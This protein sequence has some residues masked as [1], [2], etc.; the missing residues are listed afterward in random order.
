MADSIEGIPLIRWRPSTTIP[1]MACG[2]SGGHITKHLDLTQLYGEREFTRR[3]RLVDI[4]GDGREELISR[5]MNEN[6]IR[7]MD[8]RT[9]QT[10]WVSPLIL[11]SKDHPPISDLAVGDI[12]NDGQPEAVIATYDG[13]ILCIDATNG[14]I[15]W[16]RK[17]DYHLDYPGL[18]LTNITE[19]EGLE[20]AFTVSN[21]FEWNRNH[22]RP[23]TN[24]LLNPSV[25]VL[26][27]DGSHAW[28]SKNYDAHNSR[29]HWTWEFD[30]D[31]DGY[32][33]IV[34]SGVNKII[35]FDNDGTRLFSVPFQNSGHADRVV[36]G[37]WSTAHPG[38]EII[39]TDGIRG[40][41]VASNSGEVLDYLDI[42]TKLGG[43]LQDITLIPA[44]KEKGPHLLAQ[45]IRTQ[46]AKTTLYDKE[47]KPVWA[48]QLGY[49]AA[50]QYT[51]VLD[52]DR[53]GEYEIATGSVAAGMD[54]QCS[55]QIMELDG[56]PL[57]WHRWNG[58]QICWIME[59]KE[60][61]PSE[62]SSLLLGTGS[63]GGKSGR[64]SLPTGG[65][66]NLFVVEAP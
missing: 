3:T 25:L 22:S 18:R 29:G 14:N 31:G 60:L 32:D 56:S 57:Y 49:A 55:I 15:Q 12:D 21:N 11:P 9:G 36:F 58:P 45:N 64:W 65:H 66:M 63:N 7:A 39:Y 35:A 26:K 17:L 24:L 2:N 10:L 20:L 50:M 59:T 53:D 33:E 37:E 38:P 46:D 48:A 41:G 13:H 23:R 19:D 6:Q 40:I 16:H 5:T 47:L 34:V 62:S 52:W 28:I 30:L 27:S 51:R 4:D 42:P 54:H 61:A 43:H 44:M 8:L 1:T